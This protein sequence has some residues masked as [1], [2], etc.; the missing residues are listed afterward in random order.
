[1]T[2]T[3]SPTLRPA[4]SRSPCTVVA[5]A[6]AMT[7]ASSNGTCRPMR[8]TLTS[9]TTRYSAMAPGTLKP[10]CRT[11]SHRVSSPVRQARHRPQG[12]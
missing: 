1:M 8:T 3:D 6:S 12:R 11:D 9:G 7:A 4:R 10:T 5:T 2:S